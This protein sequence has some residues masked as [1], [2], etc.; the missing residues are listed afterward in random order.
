M[1]DIIFQKKRSCRVYFVFIVVAMFPDSSCCAQSH[2]VSFSYTV[3]TATALNDLT[4]YNTIARKAENLDKASQLEK[5][6]LS[7]KAEWIRKLVEDSNNEHSSLSVDQQKILDRLWKRVASKSMFLYFGVDDS[8]PANNRKIN[9]ISIVGYLEDDSLDEELNVDELVEDL[10]ELKD[11][12]H[13]RMRHTTISQEAFNKL[14]GLPKLE[15]LD[16][17]CNITDNMLYAILNAMPTLKY[18]ELHGCKKI[19]GSFAKRKEAGENLVEITMINT[20]FRPENLTQII[21]LPNV[22]YV[23]MNGINIYINALTKDIIKVKE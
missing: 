21:A 3:K 12:T 5:R 7:G 16:A 10:C 17:P 13:L 22:K 18:L 8:D 11:L 15:Y 14:T 6:G 2:D 23:A 20:D 4:D 19:N 1:I 9:T